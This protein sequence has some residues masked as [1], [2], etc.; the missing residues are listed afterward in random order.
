MNE[1]ITSIDRNTYVIDE[2]SQ[3]IKHLKDKK[4]AQRIVFDSKQGWYLVSSNDQLVHPFIVEQIYEDGFYGDINIIDY[5]EQGSSREKGTNKYRPNYLYYLLYTPSESIYPNFFDGI[6]HAYSFKDFG[7]IYTKGFELFNDFKELLELQDFKETI[8]NKKLLRGDNHMNE[9]TS[10]VQQTK[11][12]TEK[13]TKY[14][15]KPIKL[16]L[17]DMEDETGMNIQEDT[18]NCYMSPEEILDEVE[19]GFDPNRE[20]CTIVKNSREIMKL[21]IRYTNP[22]DQL[23]TLTLK[24]EFLDEGDNVIDEIEE[25]DLSIQEVLEELNYIFQRHQE[26]VEIVEEATFSAQAGTAPTPSLAA[27]TVKGEPW[28]VGKTYKAVK[29]K[30]KK[31]DK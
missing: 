19:E 6:D 14:I 15:R 12:L 9:I 27:V 1:N 16:T 5:I 7:T 11:Y 23:L 31:G 28:T 25:A 4:L 26:V 29:K 2:V 10:L 18:S 13:L 24:I 30:K 3:L 21:T 8:E 20:L 17:D 22:T